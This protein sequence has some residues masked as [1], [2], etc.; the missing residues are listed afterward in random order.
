M[1]VSRSPVD[2]A[3]QERH[4]PRGAGEGAGAVAN[5]SHPGAVPH[6]L[7]NSRPHARSVTAIAGGV[8]NIENW[9]TIQ[10]V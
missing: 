2:G 3:G 7:A 6:T 4:L 1:H 5:V 9:D 10:T 8:R